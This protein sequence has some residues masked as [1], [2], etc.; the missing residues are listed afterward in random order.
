MKFVLV[1]IILVGVSLAYLPQTSSLFSGQ[2]AF[3]NI[4]AT[5]NQI[6]CTKCHGDVQLDLSGHN[7]TPHANFSCED[8][9]RIQ[10]GKA[11]GDDAV[12]EITYNATSS[13]TTQYVYLLTTLENFESNNFPYSITGT[14]NATGYDTG[15]NWTDF[16]PRNDNGSNFEEQAALQVN[17]NYF[18]QISDSSSGIVYNYSSASE[19]ATEYNG[20]PKDKNPITQN[21]LVNPTLITLLSNGYL[22]FTGAGS[23]AVTPG[24]KYHA[25][26]IIQCTYEGCHPSVM[27]DTSHATHN[28]LINAIAIPYNTA[29]DNCISC[30][31][32]VAV[33]I[34]WY[35]PNGID[36]VS[37]SDGNGNTT[38]QMNIS[39]NIQQHYQTFGN[40]SGNAIA[41]SNV[42]VIT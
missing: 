38:V 1:F 8:C 32:S 40:Q 36:I 21:N 33:T 19:I 24:T 3:Y 41:V 28:T 34:D 15:M 37:A 27:N 39:S 5:G 42:T 31:S 26:S 7:D 22:N 23:R 12:E 13:A 17:G 20:T 2:H 6:S 35:Q 25:A 30:H 11:S 16:S 18:G 4:D 29:S 14:G 10:N 9:H